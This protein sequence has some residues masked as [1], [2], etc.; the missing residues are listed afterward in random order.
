MKRG[1]R[2]AAVILLLTF[3]LFSPVGRV[4]GKL[5]VTP[6]TLN[7]KLNVLTDNLTFYHWLGP[8]APQSYIN[9]TFAWSDNNQP[10]ILY[11]VDLLGLSE[12]REPNSTHNDYAFQRN[13]TFRNGTFSWVG[14]EGWTIKNSTITKGGVTSTHLNLTLDTVSSSRASNFT[15]LAQ[16]L[17]LGLT[18]YGTDA[19]DR[20]FFGNSYS[21]AQ[22][23]ADVFFNITQWKWAANSSLNN[24]ALMF[25]IYA[26]NLTVIQRLGFRLADYIVPDYNFISPEELKA[27]WAPFD[28]TAFLLTG[29]N[30]TGTLGATTLGYFASLTRNETGVSPPIYE[31]RLNYTLPKANSTTTL[32]F[33]R[34]QFASGNTI[35]PGYFSLPGFAV[36]L[37]SSG[38]KKGSLNVTTSY[39]STGNYVRLFLGYP[40][41]STDQLRHFFSFGVDDK[42]LPAEPTPAG[43]YIVL[44]TLPLQQA[45]IIGGI[46]VVS[47]VI[48]LFSTRTV[49]RAGLES[50]K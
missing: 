14:N 17:T 6:D 25:G 50:R 1:L 27:R 46:A 8:P 19:S 36:G 12:F 45:L 38:N 24:L 7:N 26:L 32:P 33:I 10:S 9:P 16:N 18:I 47:I 28:P 49:R 13:E 20:K 31:H 39:I 3:L 43:V 30:L 40:Y 5:T 11:V 35:L 23:R 21:V 4:Q 2:A 44:P 29:I 48:A 22:S 15:Y 42:F 37:D 34:L 41:F